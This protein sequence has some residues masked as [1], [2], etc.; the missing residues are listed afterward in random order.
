MRLK[1]SLVYIIYFHEHKHISIIHPQM[2]IFVSIH[3]H[4]CT[5]RM[6]GI[7][8]CIYEY[9][10][11]LKTWFVVFLFNLSYYYKT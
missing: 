11:I 5:T 1:Y 9:V 10:K 8:V 7:Y 3:T 2:Q 4:R 6:C